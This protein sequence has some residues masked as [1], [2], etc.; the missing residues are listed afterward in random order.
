MCPPSSVG[1]TPLLRYYEDIRLPMHLQASSWFAMPP[2]PVLQGV[3]RISRVPVSTLMT[4]H[5]LRPGRSLDALVVA[6]GI[7][8]PD[9]K[10][11]LLFYFVIEAQS[12]HAFAL[13]P[14][15]SC[16]RF[17]GL[18]TSLNATLGTQCRTKASEVRFCPDW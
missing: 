8:F 14:I 7:A 16:V 3:H 18:V 12:L 10:Q 17:A 1:V 11:H 15:I 9:T 6:S 4:C 2:Y 13:Q 5:G